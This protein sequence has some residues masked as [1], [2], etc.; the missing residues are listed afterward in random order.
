[1]N[2]AYW[3]QFDVEHPLQK[4]PRIVLLPP[5][6]Y[7]EFVVSKCAC[8]AM[9][10]SIVSKQV[11]LL[12]KPHIRPP[13]LVCHD[14]KV[15]APG[16]FPSHVSEYGLERHTRSLQPPNRPQ[17]GARLSA[18]T[19]RTTSP[20]VVG[21][22]LSARSMSSSVRTGAN[23]VASNRTSSVRSLL[24]LKPSSF[25]IPF[26]SSVSDVFTNFFSCACTVAALSSSFTFASASSSE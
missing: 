17:S 23:F 22:L 2:A 5:A 24:S 15:S 14:V 4:A 18:T 20:N 10:P 26:A 12:F 21:T 19:P 13:Y 25:A 11:V 1:M 8:A 7:R 3:A 9:P 6:K 16:F